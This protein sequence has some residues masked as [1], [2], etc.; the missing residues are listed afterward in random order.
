[1]LDESGNALPADQVLQHFSDATGARVRVRAAQGQV[2]TLHVFAAAGGSGVYTLS[3]DVLPQVVSVEA[4]S[5]LP[6]GP[7]TSLVLTLQGDRLDPATAEDPANYTITW[8]GPDGQLGTSD[9]QVIHPAAGPGGQPV[10][11]NPGVNTEVASGH[12]YPTAV[13]QT[14]TFLFDSPLPAGSYEIRLAPA[15]QSAAFNDA[16]A[17]LLAGNAAF[18][19]HPVVSVPNGKIEN[20]SRLVVTGLVS[21]PGAGGDLGTIGQG[22][23][24]LTQFHGDLGAL[25]DE[26]LRRLGDDPSITAALNQQILDRFVPGAQVTVAIIWLDPVSLDLADSQGARA[27]YNVQG[28]TASNTLARTF[29]QTG[30]NVE[31]MVLAGVTG[32]FTLNI[33]D[34]PTTA[35]GGFVVVNGDKV[36]TA[37]LTDAIRAGARTFEVTIPGVNAPGTTGVP[38]APGG[39]PTATV[40]PV[41]AQAASPPVTAAAEGNSAGSAGGASLANLAANFQLSTLVAQVAVQSIVL[42]TFTSASGEG[43]AAAPREAGAGVQ[44]SA[45][46]PAGPGGDPN[47]VPRPEG[48]GHRPDLARIL[49]ALEGAMLYGGGTADFA[50]YLRV[51]RAILQTLPQNGRVRNPRRAAAAPEVRLDALPPELAEVLWREG[52]PEDA[53]SEL[54]PEAPA[55]MWPRDERGTDL[56]AFLGLAMLTGGACSPGRRRTGDRG[57][58]PEA[59]EGTRKPRVHN[60]SA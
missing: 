30:G 35:R 42:L 13:Q 45:A 58:G 43:G 3:I 22:T 12:T 2:L 51:L 18:A 41:V 56:L 21:A 15:I 47:E 4:Q 59:G 8:L 54:P 7:A 26:L 31:V 10:V 55:E 25:L 19:G 37:A 53:A 32:T 14:V 33:A 6:G 20:G 27:V 24:A 16:E 50:S 36:Q 40:P 9:D 48:Q 23:R 57:Q 49:E 5:P 17:G 60:L 28:N 1:V 39:T 38:T 44:G 29:M 52:C 46:T 11:Y 34:V